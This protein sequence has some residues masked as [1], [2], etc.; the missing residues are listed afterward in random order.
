MIPLTLQLRI[1]LAS[2]GPCPEDLSEGGSEAEDVISDFLETTL[3][4]IYKNHGDKNL[5]LHCG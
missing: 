4:F 1:S 3:S 5:T 2:P